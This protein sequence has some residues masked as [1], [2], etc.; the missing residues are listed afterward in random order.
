M[1][2]LVDNRVTCHAAKVL[3][4]KRANLRYGRLFKEKELLVD[5]Q[6]IEGKGRSIKYIVYFDEIATPK[7]FSTRSIRRHSTTAGSNT[8][9]S[10]PTPISIL[11]YEF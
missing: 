1:P 5:V 7:A 10:I 6:R 4:E 11:R 2:F 9:A 3:G 8:E